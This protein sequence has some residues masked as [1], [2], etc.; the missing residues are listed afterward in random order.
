MMPTQSDSADQAPPQLRAGGAIETIDINALAFA[1]SVCADKHIKLIF[2][3]H[4]LA[5]LAIFV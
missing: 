4:A 2:A 1:P 5:S 3:G